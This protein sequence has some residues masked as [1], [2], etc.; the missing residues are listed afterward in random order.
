VN[1]L[2]VLPVGAVEFD[3]RGLAGWLARC[4]TEWFR[5]YL[6]LPGR[7]RAAYLA[8]DFRRALQH[9][10]GTVFSIYDGGRDL[11]AVCAILPLDWDS[12]HF[13]LSCA[14]LGPCCTAPAA[15]PNLRCALYARI[16]D[17]VLEV[18]AASGVRLLH[19]RLLSSR[20]DEIRALQTRG[21]LLA[22]N[23]VTLTRD[24]RRM[25]GRRLEPPGV[26]FRRAV[27]EDC[28]RIAE[29][30]THSYGLSRF[31]RDRRL[32]AEKGY[33]VYARWA[34]ALVDEAPAG[35]DKAG[36]G[37]ELWVCEAEG[38]LAG[39]AGIGLESE[40]GIVTLELF[41]VAPEVRRRGIGTCLLEFVC[42]QASAR[43]ADLVEASTWINARGA[44][45]VYQRAG[46]QVRDSLMSFHR[47]L[48]PV[49]E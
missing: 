38:V 5:D 36:R 35:G 34:R 7:A 45:A 9:P 12:E 33:D 22:D 19:R 41:A 11:R 37:S 3:S 24:L 8:A 6:G 13:G 2:T 44:M 49:D 18:A 15:D 16:L 48:D 1:G 42:A 21:F 14:R 47:W 32:G 17:H 23:V 43:G 25:P 40:L 4:E 10:R 30:G 29:I 27:L 31:V 28:E 46:F 39:Y 26:R 20:D